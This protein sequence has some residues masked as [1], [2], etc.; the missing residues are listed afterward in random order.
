MTS[1]TWANGPSGNTPLSA[2]ALNGIEADLDLRPAKWQPLTNY[3][4]GQLVVS[5][6]QDIVAAISTH[7]SGASYTPANW[8]TSVTFIPTTAKAVPNGVPS[9]D[10]SGLLPQAQLP[11]A[12]PLKWQPLTAYTVNQQVITPNNDLAYCATAHTSGASFDYTKWGFSAQS[13]KIGGAPFGASPW[14]VVD[15]AS[16]TT[17]SN[18]VFSG[19]F[20]TPFPNSCKAIFFTPNSGTAIIP[21]INGGA[22]SKTG[23]TAVCIG[24]S[25]ATAITYSYVAYGW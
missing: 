19:T 25:S 13:V 23:F 11:A 7:T 3:T 22:L 2:T 10:G 15:S 14:T 8:N 5:P 1:R 17:A 6:N 24:M 18:G 4:A 20:A 21:V 12:V 16:V 9:L